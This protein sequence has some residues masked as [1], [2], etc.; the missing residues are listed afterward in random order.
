MIQIFDDL[1]SIE[2]QNKIEQE[3]LSQEYVSIDNLNSLK[4]NT[5]YENGLPIL[6]QE[7]VM[8]ED[9]E[10]NLQSYLRKILKTTRSK[11]KVDF[12][13][14]T[15]WKINKLSP[16][17]DNSIDKWGV[18]VDSFA[19]HYSIIYYINDSDGD[20][21]FYNDTLGDR[22]KEWMSILSNN[23]DF[24]YWKENKRVSPKK[25]R[26]VIFDGRIFHRSSYPTTQDRYI[27]NFNVGIS[28]KKLE[29]I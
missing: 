14:A 20:T 11:S 2:D 18:H 17:K 15:R 3:V 5:S 13:P 16:I 27:L 12:G 4:D 24:S 29:L 6:E 9:I 23:K 21:V 25:G 26:I 8:G 10:G 7:G 28:N 19:P 1:L 22:F